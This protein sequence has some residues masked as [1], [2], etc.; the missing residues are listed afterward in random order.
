M[1]FIDLTKNDKI[2]LNV[3]KGSFEAHLAKNLKDFIQCCY[4]L[5]M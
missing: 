3:W 5:S 1:D 4:L 2:D